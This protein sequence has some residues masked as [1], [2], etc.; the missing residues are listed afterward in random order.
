MQDKNGD[1]ELE[2][3]P[4]T[5]ESVLDKAMWDFLTPDHFEDVVLSSIK[6]IEKQ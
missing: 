3:E 1:P 6:V 5:S 4:S 2:E